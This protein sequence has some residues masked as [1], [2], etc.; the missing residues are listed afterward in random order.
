MAELEARASTI[1]SRY[2]TAQDRLTTVRNQV[3]MGSVFVRDA[4]LDPNPAHA[5]DYRR[6]LEDAYRA[7]DEALQ[8]YQPVSDARAEADRIARLRNDI[9]EFRRT[10]LDV[11]ATDSR[12][13]TADAPVLLRERIMPKRQGVMRVSEEVQALNRHAFVEQHG[14]IRAV[15]RATQRRLWESFGLSVV[16][17]LGI[18]LLAVMYVGRLE[19]RIQRQRDAEIAASET[20]QQL[21]TRLLSA[22][23]DERRTIARELHDEVGQVLT[24]IKVELSLAERAIEAGAPPNLLE[25]ARLLTDGAL[26]SVRDLSHLLHPSLLDDLG[27]PAAVEWY[28]TGFAR[29]HRIAMTV[30]HDGMA[31]RLVPEVEGSIYRIVQEALTNVARH[32][33]ARTCTV[34]LCRD[35]A[36]LA[37]TV[38]DDGVGIN[39][40]SSKAPSEKRGLGLLGIAER[41]AALGGTVDVNSAPGAGTRVIARVPARAAAL[42]RDEMDAVDV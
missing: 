10:L 11:L 28:A 27:L 22:Q 6:E 41:V 1:N 40:A 5:A 2:T 9:G 32:S 30:H 24:A 42:P 3:L 36:W 8:Q 23:E 38:A 26:H 20:L 13:W 4:L 15:Y 31:E 21:S 35:G 14:A 12:S 33:G 7:A 19:Q 34:D 17:S 29:R 37:V 18:A 16:A 25:E 39:L